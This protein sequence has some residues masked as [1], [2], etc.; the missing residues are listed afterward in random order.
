MGSRFFLTTIVLGLAMTG[1]AGPIGFEDSWAVMG[2]TQPDMVDFQASY[3]FTHKVG[4]GVDYGH[5]TMEGPERQWVI[6]RFNYLVSRWNGPDHQANIYLSAGGGAGFKNEVYQPA[7]F[8]AVEADYETRSIYF[9]GKASATAARDF[10]SLVFYQLRAGVAPYLADF[11]GFHSWIVIQTQY[12]PN[13]VG[14]P[15]RVGPL[16]RFY[17]RNVLWEIGATT[18]S[19]WNFNFMIHF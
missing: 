1:F 16:M 4:L 3:S 17:Y 2:Y 9:S 5:D 7:V 12:F 10:Q 18:K 13:A 6:G 11:E 8:G 19:T 15:V 14:Y